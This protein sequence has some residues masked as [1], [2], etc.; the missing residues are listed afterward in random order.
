MCAAVHLHIF[1]ASTLLLLEGL[2]LLHR[3][4]FH[5]ADLHWLV[6]V[7]SDEPHQLIHHL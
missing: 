4:L 1:E 7:H 5:V 2:L 6:V 3:V